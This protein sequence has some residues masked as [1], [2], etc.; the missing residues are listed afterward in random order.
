MLQ[1]A[2]VAQVAMDMILQKGHQWEKKV[3]ADYKLETVPGF[4]LD[5][6]QAMCVIFDNT[7]CAEGCIEAEDFLHN[8]TNA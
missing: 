7:E 3:F 1:R 2:F 8:G 4:Y 5:L 6:T